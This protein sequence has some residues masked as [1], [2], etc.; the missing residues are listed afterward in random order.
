M[1]L[2]PTTPHTPSIARRFLLLPADA[3]HNVAIFPKDKFKRG[4]WLDVTPR[5]DCLLPPV[6]ESFIGRNLDMHATI[7]SVLSQHKRITVLRGSVRCFC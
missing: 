4:D 5:L 3:N 6:P 7:K 2:V 1:T